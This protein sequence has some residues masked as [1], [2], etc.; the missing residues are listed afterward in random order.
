MYSIGGPSV[1]RDLLMYSIAE[2]SVLVRFTGVFYSWCL[3]L[4]R[5]TGVFYSG[6]SVLLRFI[7]VFYSHGFSVIEIYRCIL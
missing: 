2:G 3:F 1:Y 4:L 5:F 7:D 6:P